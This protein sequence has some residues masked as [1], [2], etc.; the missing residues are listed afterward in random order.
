MFELSLKGDS[1]SCISVSD[2]TKTYGKNVALNGLSFNVPCGEKVALLGPNGAG[3]STTLKLLVGLLV[4]DRGAVS[5]MGNDPSSTE[6][7]R[8]LGYL[9]EDASPYLTLS[10]RENLE[11]IGSLRGVP[12]VEERVDTLLDTLT[13]RDNERAKVSKLSRG[14]RQKLSVALSIIHRPKIVLLDEP[15]NYLD[16]PTQEKVIS[17]FRDLNA[18]FLVSTHIMAIAERLTDRAIVITR[19]RKVWSGTMEELRGLGEP[20][21]AIESIVTRLM[22]VV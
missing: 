18:T 4:P 1:R 7:K 17:M 15:L 16:I 19:G 11:Y 5:I 21:E 2:V 22:T 14:N 20:T 13:L 12:N 3:K 8:L 6:A 9:P 10:V